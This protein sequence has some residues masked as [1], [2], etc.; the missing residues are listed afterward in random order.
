MSIVVVQWWTFSCY[1]YRFCHFF[2]SP[3]LAQSSV[4]REIEAVDSGMI[5]LP[6]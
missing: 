5:L 1:G 3:M 2:V 4:E 6:W